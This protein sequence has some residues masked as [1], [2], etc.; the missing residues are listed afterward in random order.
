MKTYRYTREDVSK[1]LSRWYFES[2]YKRAIEISNALLE[3]KDS[4][5]KTKKKEKIQP[6]N[7]ANTTSTR[8][9]LRQ[10]E[11]EIMMENKINELIEMVNNLVERV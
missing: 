8:P 9:E 11:K 5:K 3:T 2:D 1:M 4:T 6:L 7:L 10:T